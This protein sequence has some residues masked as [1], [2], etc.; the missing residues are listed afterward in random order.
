[1]LSRDV[2]YAN[3]TLQFWSLKAEVGLYQITIRGSEASYPF[4]NY[5]DWGDAISLLNYNFQDPVENVL[6]YIEDGDIHRWSL[7][8]IRELNC[9]TNPHIYEQGLLFS[10]LLVSHVI[11]LQLLR[12]KRT[13]IEKDE[14]LGRSKNL[15]ICRR[16]YIAAVLQA[17]LLD[18]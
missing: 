13:V 11:A 3:I 17:S 14:I 12:G 7:L 6:K 2:D 4:R 9:I 5:T 10:I 15:F 1:M 16:N 8:D 18:K